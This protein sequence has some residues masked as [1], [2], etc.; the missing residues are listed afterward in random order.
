MEGLSNKTEDLHKYRALV[1]NV[2][3]VGKNEVLYDKINRTGL[4]PIFI[5]KEEYANLLSELNTNLPASMKNKKII[6]WRVGSYQYRIINNG[7]NEYIITE[8]III[9]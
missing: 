3:N 9:E 4:K 6:T 2:D 8:R 1:N 7:F 5:E